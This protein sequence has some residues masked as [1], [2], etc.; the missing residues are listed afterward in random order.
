[1][2][3]KIAWRNIW[4]NRRRTFITS[5]AI[6]FAV[7]FAIF[8]DSLQK[9]VWDTTIDNSVKHHVGYAQVHKKGY[10]DD[11]RIDM[12]MDWNTK[13]KEQLTALPKIKHVNARL[14]G[15]AIAY[16]FTDTSSVGV[17]MVGIE[18]KE[19]DSFSGIQSKIVDGEYIR[20]DDKSILIVQ[21]F[22]EKQQL[23]VGDTLTFIS[24][25]YHGANAAAR[26]PIKGIINFGNPNFN[27][28]MIYLP[29]KEA[30][31][32]F[33]AEGLANSVVLGLDSRAALPQLLAKANT[34][35][36]SSKYEIMSWE[37]LLPAIVQARELKM[38]GNKVI[39]GILY[40]IVGFGILGTIL[41]MTK[42]RQY[43][44][45]VLTAIGMKRSQLALSVWLE[46]IMLGFLGTVMG[47]ILALPLVYFLHYYPINMGP[48]FAETMNEFGVEP[49]IPT[50]IDVNIFINQAIVVFFLTSILAL[51][52]IL[53]ILRL[54]PIKAM[55]S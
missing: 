44:F 2:I 19:E 54:K 16:N 14:E 6:L 10:W 55:R 9:G 15:F 45:G 51:Y 18:P 24:Q 23:K 32:F 48:S 38:S 1:M 30:Q 20:T 26:Y 46:T 36:D 7:F 43:E 49:I 53:K 12:S 35:L 13:L 50:A 22:A 34:E 28:Q 17:L 41:M 8:M 33:A 40:F 52:P 47:M 21:G 4:R 31:W 25:G 3:F 39:L 27:R 5:S 29:L 42:E 11:Q 37:E